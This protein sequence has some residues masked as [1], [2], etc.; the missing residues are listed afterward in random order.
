MMNIYTVEINSTPKEC[1][2]IS[3]RPTSNYI[4]FY[5][6]ISKRLSEVKSNFITTYRFI[7]IID[8]KFTR[9]LIPIFYH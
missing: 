4:R 5:T 9:N 8:N 1:F 2:I 7:L 3:W 6:K